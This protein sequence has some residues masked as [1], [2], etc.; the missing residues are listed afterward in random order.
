MESPSGHRESSLQ[1]QPS[2]G[3]QRSAVSPANTSP[4]KN[5]ASRTKSLNGSLQTVGSVGSVGEGTARSFSSGSNG[6]GWKQSS[7]GGLC[8][9]QH[10]TALL[11]LFLMTFLVG[12]TGVF[13]SAVSFVCVIQ[14]EK[15][16]LRRYNLCWGEGYYAQGYYI[17]LGRV[18]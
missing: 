6:R 1:A 10:S 9:G 7:G 8:A 15:N 13:L 2:S 17:C 3:S 12:G 16:C 4:W 14:A 11:M 5:G 18:T